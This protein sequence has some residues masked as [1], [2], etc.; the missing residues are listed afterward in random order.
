[1]KDAHLLSGLY[2]LILPSIAQKVARTL[3]SQSPSAQP[4]QRTRQY[5][6]DLDAEGNDE[7]LQAFGQSLELALGASEILRIKQ[8]PI[9]LQSLEGELHAYAQFERDN[10]KTKGESVEVVKA[11]A[12]KKQNIVEEIIESREQITGSIK[13]VTAFLNGMEVKPPYNQDVVDLSAKIVEA[14]NKIKKYDAS[15]QEPAAAQQE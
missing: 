8:F 10:A 3:P 4:S 14:G 1:L 15:V 6:G 7:R 11:R 12:I 2:G 13:E 9:Q 5:E